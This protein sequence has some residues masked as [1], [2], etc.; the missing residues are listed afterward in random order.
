MQDSTLVREY[1]GFEIYET[2][3]QDWDYDEFLNEL[4]GDVNICGYTYTA[5]RALKLVDPI[6]YDCGFSDMQE[7]TYTVEAPSDTIGF[8]TSQ[9][10]ETEHDARNAI[11]EWLADSR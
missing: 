2:E 8:D 4:Y 5:S 10:F 9:T 11:D 7:Y 1:E 3:R 6:A